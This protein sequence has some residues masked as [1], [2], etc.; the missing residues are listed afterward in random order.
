MGRVDLILQHL[1][2]YIGNLGDIFFFFFI[3][4]IFKENQCLSQSINT[5]T[6]VFVTRI[7][8][9]TFTT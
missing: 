7:K 9:T 1:V 5:R 2:R 6:V 8:Y 4:I 3:D